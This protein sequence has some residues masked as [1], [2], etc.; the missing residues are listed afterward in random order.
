M[1]LFIACLLIY[2][3]NLPWWLYPIALVIWIGRLAVT[4][5]DALRVP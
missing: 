1:T 5:I 3:L 2:A 4:T